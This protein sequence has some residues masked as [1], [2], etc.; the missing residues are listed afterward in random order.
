MG[1]LIYMKKVFTILSFFFIAT[2]GYS[3]YIEIDNYFIRKEMKILAPE[4]FDA[5]DRLDTTCTKLLNISYL[6]VSDNELEYADSESELYQLVFGENGEY[7]NKTFDVNGLQY[8][9][10]L[11]LLFIS[12]GYMNV[13]A[14]KKH[15]P[16]RLKSVDASAENYNYIDYPGGLTIEIPD[17]VTYV[18]LNGETNSVRCILPTQLEEL[19]LFY[20]D[21]KYISGIMNT[22]VKRIFT[23]GSN[24]F[25]EKL[26]EVPNTLEEIQMSSTSDDWGEG[27]E[28]YLILPQSLPYLKKLTFEDV[29][30]DENNDFLNTTS[31]NKLEEISFINSENYQSINYPSSLKKLF[32]MDVFVLA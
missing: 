25:Y 19:V 31:F 3:Q 28:F 21:P 11:D 26:E 13:N 8:L 4:C 12:F 10:N 29:E 15:L 23:Y 32:M 20:C 5:Q 6:D 17:S 22:K 2:S 27:D 18:S 24:F 7:L 30:F 9:I 16:K 1:K 14:E